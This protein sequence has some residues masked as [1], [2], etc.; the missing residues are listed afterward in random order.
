[1][2]WE[3]LARRYQLSLCPMATGPGGASCSESPAIPTNIPLA[4]VP[5][6]STMLPGL[7]AAS[8]SSSSLRSTMLPGLPAISQYAR[9]LPVVPECSQVVPRSTKLF[10]GASW[11]FHNTPRV[12]SSLHVHQVAPKA[13]KGERSGCCRSL[14]AHLALRKT[15]SSLRCVVWASRP[16]DC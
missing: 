11:R 12:P 5:G 7:Q 4:S 13:S 2:P 10:P 15:P 1:M 8:P 14:I 16:G 9:L 6:G 3:G